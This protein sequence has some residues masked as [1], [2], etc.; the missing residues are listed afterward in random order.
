LFE[1]STERSLATALLTWAWMREGRIRQIVVKKKIIGR[2]IVWKGSSVQ[3]KL[4]DYQ[5]EFEIVTISQ[6]RIS[7][8]LHI[9]LVKN[10]VYD[11]E[12]ELCTSVHTS[13]S[14][15][16]QSEQESEGACM[17]WRAFRDFRCLLQQYWYQ[18]KAASTPPNNSHF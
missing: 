9:Y 2:T 16:I 11:I 12:K 3:M 8:T 6:R 18:K 4:I 1:T 10:S 13:Y 15:I 14:D 7:T 17:A 5:Q